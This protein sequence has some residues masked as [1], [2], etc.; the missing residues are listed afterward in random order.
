MKDLYIKM[1]EDAGDKFATKAMVVQLAGQDVTD[2]ERGK[3]M[4]KIEMITYLMGQLVG[5]EDEAKT[6][7]D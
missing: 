4:G 7:R 3:T 2:Y 6:I 1:L 5:E